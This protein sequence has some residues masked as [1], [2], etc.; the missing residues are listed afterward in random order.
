MTHAEHL[1]APNA[2]LVHRLDAAAWG[3]F[4][5]WVGIA[6]FANFGW[7]LGLLGVGAITLGGQIA[8]RS[9]GLVLE[10]FW[11]VVGVLFV[12]AGVWQFLR[13]QFSLIPVVLIVAGVALLYSAVRRRSA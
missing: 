5:V 1:P 2:Q 6:L 13:V 3:I 10:G 12:L 8:R 11:V 9:F 7:G 4:F